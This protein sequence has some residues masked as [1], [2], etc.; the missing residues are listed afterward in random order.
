[1]RKAAFFDVD[2]TLT[3]AHTWRGIVEYFL[4]RGERRLTYLAFWLYHFPLYL[5][6]KLRL[7]PQTAFRKPWAAHLAWFF[8]GDS[9][10]NAKRV[11]DW[12]T[13]DYFAPSW[14]S[15]SLELIQN[16]QAAGDLV[17]LVSASPAPLVRRVAE[18]LGADLAVGTEFEVQAGGYT[19]RPAGEICIAENKARLTKEML[20][21]G[22]IE[23]DFSASKAYADSSGDLDLLEMVGHPVALY[24]DA[25]L[26]PI[27]EERGWRIMPG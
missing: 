22:G 5:L 3:P 8:R 7:L 12:V 11:W 25:H 18:E 9:P 20:R 27:A 19:G 21:E 6:F 23:V 4:R 16:H 1:M 15:L 14:H 24:P 10:E 2:G 26:R 13:V 17:V